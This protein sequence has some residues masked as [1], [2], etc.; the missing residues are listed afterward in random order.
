M[1]LSA[2][3]IRSLYGMYDFNLD[4]NGNPTAI[5]GINGTGKTGILQILGLFATDQFDRLASTDFADAKLTFQDKSDKKLVFSLERDDDGIKVYLGEGPEPKQLR[6]RSSNYRG[7]LFTAL[8][9]SG[10]DDDDDVALLMHGTPTVY[11]STSRVSEPDGTTDDMMASIRKRL[12]RS[13]KPPLNELVQKAKKSF[14]DGHHYAISRERLQLQR[15]RDKLVQRIADPLILDLTEQGDWSAKLNTVSKRLEKF[16]DPN[17][18]PFVE[19]NETRLLENLAAA[20]PSVR[21]GAR[22]TIQQLENLQDTIQQGFERI[23]NIKSRINNYLEVLNELF[24][25]HP[26]TSKSFKINPDDN[27]LICYSNKSGNQVDL[28]KLSSGEK[29]LFFIVT[30]ATFGFDGKTP[31]ALLLIDEPELSLHVKW[32][33]MLL[34]TLGRLNPDLQIIVATHS[35]EIAG[36]AEPY[37]ISINGDD[38]NDL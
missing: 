31:P 23:Q 29:E 21:F 4:F 15:I 30:S 7:D 8:K 17:G 27:S 6:V 19:I 1:R 32:Q 36:S 28:A 37:V 33:E 13:E 10:D 34:P 25:I 22:A 35:P 26:L 12:D 9:N 2:V 3:S 14:G 20:D 16:L 24:Q 38:G 18:R 11:I 5:H